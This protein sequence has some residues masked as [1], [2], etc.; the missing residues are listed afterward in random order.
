MAN[1]DSVN[2]IFTQ[3][4]DV[5]VM[6]SYGTVIE[7][8]SDK[9][10]KIDKVFDQ[11]ISHFQLHY[12]SVGKKGL[13]NKHKS[14]ADHF[15]AYCIPKNM[16]GFNF[17]KQLH[18][19]NTLGTKDY[20]CIIHSNAILYKISEEEIN[21]IRQALENNNALAIVLYKI[22]ATNAHAV[23]IGYDEKNNCYFIKDPVSNKIIE[24]DI[25]AHK[26]ICEYIVFKENN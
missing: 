3:K 4:G 15:H 8:F 2:K 20:C 18:E 14:V 5:C 22:D 13:A 10:L 23:T 6:A 16:R 19:D 24:D 9:S 1:K 25:L 11:Y 7:Y 17:I 26:E 21:D 12:R